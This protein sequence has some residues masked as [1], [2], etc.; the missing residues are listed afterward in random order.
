[1][2]TYE[3][4][5]AITLSILASRR[6]TR[7]VRHVITRFVKNSCGAF[8]SA[9]DRRVRGADI[10]PDLPFPSDPASPEVAVRSSS[11]GPAI[12]S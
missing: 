4:W 5:C 6:R 12:A 10:T 8:E 9:R 3:Q 1:M 7:I 11:P 2:I